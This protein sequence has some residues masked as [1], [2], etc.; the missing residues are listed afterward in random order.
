MSVWS[1]PPRLVWGRLARR[2]RTEYVLG[3][4]VFLLIAV[5]GLYIVK[6]SPYFHRA[7]AAAV[8]H[9]LGP[10]IVSGSL[11]SATA[12]EP[13]IEA[14]L[15]YSIAYFAAVWQAVLLGMLMAAT[16]DTLVPR[17]WLVRV[18]GGRS[19]RSSLLG[20]MLALPSMM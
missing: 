14:A 3:F 18:L 10:S 19:F 8:T 16:I 12:P 5:V 4:G 20:G 1:V 15:G 13:S 17:D 6:W 9:T 7:F 11:E 2:R